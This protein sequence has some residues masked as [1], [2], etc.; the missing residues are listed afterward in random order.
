MRVFVAGATGA[1]GRRLVPLLTGSGHEVTGMTRR[2]ERAA[3]L[4]A[5]GAQPAICDVYDAPAVREAVVASEAEVL[6]HELTDIPQAL[7]IR[8]YGEQMAG[9]DR[10]RREGTPNLIAAALAAGTRRVVAQSVAFAYAPSGR[11]VKTEEDPLFVEAPMPFRRSIDALLALESA[12]TGTPGIEGVVLRYGFFYGPGTS[13]ASGGSQA[14]EVRRQRFPIVGKGEGVFS[15]IHVEDAATATAAAVERGAPGIYNVVD[16]EPAPLSE[17]LPAYAEALGARRPLRVPAFLAR[18][19]AGSFAV[20]AATV[21]RGASNAKARRELGWEPR[22]P[23]W[24]VG[25]R[26]ALG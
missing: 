7:D 6:V 12:V 1:L 22:Y 10:V 3:D 16:D 14:R 15:F 18:L 2:P 4:V 20:S 9:N 13:Y 25:F 5:M 24:R 11:A 8:R 19:L 23:T 21:Q 26:Q 17:W